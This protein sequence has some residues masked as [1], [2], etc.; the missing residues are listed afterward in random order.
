[1]PRQLAEYVVEKTLENHDCDLDDM[2]TELTQLYFQRIN[3][4]AST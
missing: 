1:M 4:C 3:N 2:K